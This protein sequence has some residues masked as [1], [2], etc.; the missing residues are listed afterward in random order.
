MYGDLVIQEHDIDRHFYIL[1]LATY[2]MQTPGKITLHEFAHDMALIIQG[3]GCDPISLEL[4]F[5]V[6]RYCFTIHHCTLQYS[7]DNLLRFRWCHN[8]FFWHPANPLPVF[9]QPYIMYSIRN[10]F[11]GHCQKK[12]FLNNFT[13]IAMKPVNPYVIW[14]RIVIILPVLQR[15]ILPIF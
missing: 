1:A 12:V 6:S 7:L 10:C 8:L 3:D 15:F 9:V 11:L 4:C 2:L 14:H 13:F 5:V